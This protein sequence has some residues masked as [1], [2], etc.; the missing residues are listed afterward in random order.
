MHRRRWQWRAFLATLVVATIA[1]VGCTFPYVP[2]Y[3]EG[4]DSPKCKAGDVLFVSKANETAFCLERKGDCQ[5]D[6]VWWWIANDVR[7]CV[8]FDN[9]MQGE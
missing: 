4:A 8:S 3:D 6:E 5:E 7:G 2:N 9:L 1:V